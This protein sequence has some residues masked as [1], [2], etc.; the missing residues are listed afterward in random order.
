MVTTAGRQSL[1]KCGGLPYTNTLKGRHVSNGLCVCI[2][3]PRGRTWHK[4]PEKG[5][6]NTYVLI[7]YNSLTKMGV[8]TKKETLNPFQTANANLVHTCTINLLCHHTFNEFFQF[9]QS[10]VLI[11]CLLK[12]IFNIFL[13][14]DAIDKCT[15]S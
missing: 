3:T 15:P 10:N 4:E 1:K 6:I 12:L 7:Q 5:Q 11:G 2:N 9:F 13:E 14:N 8:Y